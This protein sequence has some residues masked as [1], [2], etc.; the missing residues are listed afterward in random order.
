MNLIKVSGDVPLFPIESSRMLLFTEKIRVTPGRPR[1]PL[2]VLCLAYGVTSPGS[3][4]SEA[5]R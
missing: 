1:H 5:F 4:S 3:C 2:E